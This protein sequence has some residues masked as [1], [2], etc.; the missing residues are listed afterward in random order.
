MWVCVWVC[1]ALISTYT[2]NI[3]KNSILDTKT[4]IWAE[5]LPLFTISSIFIDIFLHSMEE[6]VKIQTKRNIVKFP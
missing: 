5:N 6:M 2:K 1:V 4:N 3:S